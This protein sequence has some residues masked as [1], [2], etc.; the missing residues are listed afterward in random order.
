MEPGTDARQVAIAYDWCAGLLTPQTRA[1][2]EGRLKQATAAP[3]QDFASA[4]TKAFAAIALADSAAL[5]QV[6]QSWWRDRVAKELVAGKRVI[7]HGDFYALLELLHVVRDNVQIDLRDD[8]LP[9][10][11]DLAFQRVLSYYPAVYPAAENEYRIPHYS[12]KGEPDLKAAALTRAAELSLVAYDNNAQEMQFLQGWLM[13][14]RFVLR[15]V[16]G[17]PYEF[18]WANPYQPGLPFEKIPLYLYDERTG[19]L[20]ARSSWDE[21]ATW[22]NISGKNMQVF[23]EGKPAALALK[24]PLIIGE[25]TLVAGS[26]DTR[27]RVTEEAPRT[28]FLIGLKPRAQFDIEVDDE[29]MTEGFADSGGILKLEFVRTDN[30]AVRVRERRITK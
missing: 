5:T 2:L 19:S 27:F 14:D 15:G 20:L 9:V 11:K 21:D 25:A 8:I 6:V 16:F 18:L 1:S 23:R 12:G 3:T 26:A 28:W 30:Q 7:Q 24:Q 17:A 22:V 13:H 10:Y 29:D 4:R